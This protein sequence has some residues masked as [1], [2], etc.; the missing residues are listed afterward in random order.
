MSVSLSDRQ[1][2]SALSDFMVAMQPYT[3]TINGVKQNKIKLFGR[4][5]E[6]HRY[7]NPDKPFIVHN[8]TTCQLI[9]AGN[10]PQVHIERREVVPFN[11]DELTRQAVR[12]LMIA[13]ATPALRECNDPESLLSVITEAMC[14]VYFDHEQIEKEVEKMI[15]V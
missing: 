15:V 10:H 11:E 4:I 12:S 14:K 3:L 5:W 7:M 6:N 8:D 13:R 9:M 1:Y 2:Q